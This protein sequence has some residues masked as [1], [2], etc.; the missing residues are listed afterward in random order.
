[1]S[2]SFFVPY[3][4]THPSSDCEE[5]FTSCCK[6]VLGGFGSL[7]NIKNVLAGVPGS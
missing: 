6:H 4:T 7:N 5:T 1:M 2:V 3:R